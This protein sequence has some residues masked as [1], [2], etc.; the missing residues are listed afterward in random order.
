[1]SPKKL[2]ENEF[3]CVKCRHRVKCNKE[4]MCVKSKLNPRNKVKVHM[5]KCKC[6]HC[7]TSLT[8]FISADKYETI[9]NKYGKC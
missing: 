8:K 4:D 3:Y 5:L 9:K 2:V 7:D 1:M 6:Q